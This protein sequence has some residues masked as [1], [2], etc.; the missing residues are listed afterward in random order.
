V[1][2]ELQEFISLSMDTSVTMS[3]P[4]LQMHAWQALYYMH[5]EFVNRLKV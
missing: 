2:T 4:Q 1:I 5:N 3:P